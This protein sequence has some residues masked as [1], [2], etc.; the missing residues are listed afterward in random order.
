MLLLAGQNIDASLF[1]EEKT[2]LIIAEKHLI[3][4]KKYYCSTVHARKNQ[5]DFC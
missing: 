2:D 4:R 1:L 3:S 5:Q